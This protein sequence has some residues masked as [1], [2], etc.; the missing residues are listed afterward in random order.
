MIPANTSFPPLKPISDP[1]RGIRFRRLANINAAVHASANPITKRIFF[2]DIRDTTP[3]P[4]TAPNIAA[5]NITTKVSGS[6]FTTVVKINACRSTGIQFATFIVP[7]INLSLVCFVNFNNAVCGANAPIP[8]GS[9]K[10][11]K[12]PIAPVFHQ[13]TSP[14]NSSLCLYKS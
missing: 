6:T 12:A 3:A 13:D 5:T 7:G 8:S 10:F 4:N 2:S 9:K 11:T 1:P 14:S